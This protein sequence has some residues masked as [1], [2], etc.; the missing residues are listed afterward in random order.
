MSE[1]CL[2][3]EEKN[4][5][6]GGKFVENKCFLTEASGCLHSA[7]ESKQKWVKTPN[8]FKGSQTWG[9]LLNEDRA[10]GFIIPFYVDIMCTLWHFVGRPVFVQPMK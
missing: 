8:N 4:L 9:C 2:S 10:C 3:K 7:C 5:Y 6:T 1:G